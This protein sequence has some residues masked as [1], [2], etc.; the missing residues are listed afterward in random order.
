M[1]RWQ[2]PRIEMQLRVKVRGMDRNGNPFVQHTHTVDVSR[3]G[4]RLDWLGCLR[5][6]GETIEVRRGRRKARFRVIW[7]GQIGTPEGSQ[8]GIACLESGKNIWGAE[9]PPPRSVTYRPPRSEAAK[10]GSMPPLSS[11]PCWTRGR[12]RR[13]PRYRCFGSV[14]MV[15]EGSDRVRRGTLGD[16]SL[17]GCRVEVTRPLPTGTAMELIVSGIGLEVHAKGLIR[18]SH[19]YSGMGIRFGGMTGEHQEQLRQFI[20]LLAA[21]Q[22]SRSAGNTQGPKSPGEGCP[23]TVQETGSGRDWLGAISLNLAKESDDSR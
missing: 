16:I 2:E 4:A 23:K 18:F 12:Q 15:L 3:R 8:V 20:D 14:A 13:H 22:E 1:T 10:P 11:V 5:G 21:T 7:V 9:L 17:G 19:P 6:A